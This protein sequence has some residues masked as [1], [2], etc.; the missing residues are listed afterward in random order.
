MD[1]PNNGVDDVDAVAGDE[2]KDEMGPEPN[3]GLAEKENGVAAAADAN[4]DGAGCEDELADGWE[5]DPN[6]NVAAG[7]LPV[8]G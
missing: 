2:N 8:V 6:E 7:L 5:D 1:E 3:D 4:D